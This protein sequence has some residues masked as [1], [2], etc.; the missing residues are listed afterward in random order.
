MPVM[1]A[2][3]HDITAVIL[4]GGRARRLGGID[5]GLVELHGET[6]VARLVEDLRPQAGTLLINANRNL[7]HYRRYGHPVIPDTLDNYCGPLA[8]IASG[9]QAATTRFLLTVPC[10]A[11][12]APDRLGRDLYRAL[13]DSRAD[14]SVAHDG[15]RRQPL[16]ALLRITLLPDLLEY[17]RDGGRRVDTWYAQQQVTVVD[18]SDTPAAFLNLN[19]PAD[20][21]HLVLAAGTT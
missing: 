3:S 20:I 1:T 2:G 18:F 5:K 14:I 4:A 11:P 19:T 10:D 6:L 13:L 17:L 12:A 15:T 8:G 21:H 7:G 16:F 9:M